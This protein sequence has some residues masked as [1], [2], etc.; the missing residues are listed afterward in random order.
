[1][2]FS[3]S[4]GFYVAGYDKIYFSEEPDYEKTKSYSP[5]LTLS[6]GELTTDYQLTITITDLNDESPIFSSPSEF[7]VN[8]NQRSIGT[9]IATD[10][11]SDSI[12]YSLSGTDASALSIGSSS[13]VLVFNEAPDYENKSNIAP[14]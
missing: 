12:Y 10:A 1:M 8:E 5:I 6:D 11:D 14:S 3:I 2:S 9:V 13:S 4:E 7:S